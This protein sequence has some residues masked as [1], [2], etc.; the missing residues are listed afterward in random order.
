MGRV[1]AGALCDAIITIGGGGGTLTEIAI[2]YQAGIPIIALDRTGGWSD[3][4]SGEYIDE[5]KRMIVMTAKQPE[6]AARDCVWYRQ[7][8]DEEARTEEEPMEVEQTLKYH[9]ATSRPMFMENQKAR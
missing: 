1:H 7:E 8:G 2:A 5:R 6:E 4:L 9:D 3:R